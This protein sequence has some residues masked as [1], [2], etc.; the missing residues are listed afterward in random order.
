[1]D[2]ERLW[3]P[4]LMLALYLAGGLVVSFLVARFWAFIWRR[5][6]P[7]AGGGFAARLTDVTRRPIALLVW[8][9]AGHLGLG[10]ILRQ[11]PPFSALPLFKWLDGALYVVTALAVAWLVD[12]VLEA[13]LGWYLNDVANRT[14]TAMPLEF[15]P[16]TRRL[17][18]ILFL[19]IA[20]T[21]ILAHFGSEISMLVTTAG[22]ASLAV[23]LAAQETLAN[24]IAGLVLMIDRPFRQGDRVELGSGVVGD[25]VEVGLRTTKMLSLDNTLIVV[26]NKELAASRLTNYSFPDARMIIKI[27]LTITYDSDLETAREVLLAVARRQAGVLADPP[28]AVYV[29]DF[30]DLGLKV[31]LWI[32]VGDAKDQ[33]RVKDALAAALKEGFHQAGIKVPVIQREVQGTTPGA[34]SGERAPEPRPQPPTTLPGLGG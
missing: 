15:L 11:H 4:V 20:L 24:M 22:V 30:G 9:G 33:V 32:W 1:M 29:T 7:A 17:T 28:P 34:A 14:H 3:S 8:L 13:A 5:L 16:F 10:E 21:N 26:P 19:M 27:P 6:A 25:I 31:S 2:L 18:Q 23:A 12:A